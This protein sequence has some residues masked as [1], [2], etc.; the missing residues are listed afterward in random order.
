MLDN[1]WGAIVPPVP[2]LSLPCYGN[3]KCTPQIL[4]IHGNNTIPTTLH[5]VIKNTNF[6][7]F[8][9]NEIQCWRMS[10]FNAGFILLIHSY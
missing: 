8:M 4:Q 5:V 2:L 7:S 6:T 3:S 1:F 10:I 9:I